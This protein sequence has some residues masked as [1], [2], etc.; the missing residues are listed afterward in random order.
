MACAGAGALEEGGP[1]DGWGWGVLALFHTAEQ[2]SFRE[3][4][5]ESATSFKIRTSL[6]LEMYGIRPYFERLL[7]SS[8]FSLSSN[9][10]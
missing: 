1:G 5:D 4:M 7:V 2:M 6:R 3:F 8:H 9:T 10:L